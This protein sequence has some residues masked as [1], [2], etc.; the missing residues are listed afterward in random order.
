VGW[1]FGPSGPRPSPLSPL[2][3][4][5]DHEISSQPTAKVFRDRTTP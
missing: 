1:D 5:A 3:Q 4:K 2:L